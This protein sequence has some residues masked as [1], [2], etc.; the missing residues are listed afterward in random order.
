MEVLS[1]NSTFCFITCPEFC[2]IYELGE[3]WTGKNDLIEESYNKFDDLRGVDVG[4]EFLLI[5]GNAFE[6][7]FVESRNDRSFWWGQTSA[8]RVRARF[9]G[10]E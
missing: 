7:K 2:T 6:M 8:F 4:H 5:F 1:W 3:S 10:S 9:R